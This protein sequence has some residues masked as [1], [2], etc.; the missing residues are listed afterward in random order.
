M[1][2]RRDAIETREDLV[3][4]LKRIDGQVTDDRNDPWEIDDFSSVRHPNPMIERYRIQ[5]RDELIDLLA[6]SDPTRRAK[7]GPTINRMIL[8]IE[9]NA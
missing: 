3:A 5:V 9:S 6:S 1:S 7:I 8:E 2:T 4:F